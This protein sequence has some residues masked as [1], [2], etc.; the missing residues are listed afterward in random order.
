MLDNGTKYC[1]WTHRVFNNYCLSCPQRNSNRYFCPSGVSH[2][3]NFAAF[4]PS[5]AVVAANQAREFCFLFFFF[6][7]FKWSNETAKCNRYGTRSDF[8]IQ[9]D[10]HINACVPTLVSDVYISYHFQ[11][12]DT[13]TPPSI[14][15]RRI[16]VVASFARFRDRRRCLNGSV[17]YNAIPRLAWTL[18]YSNHLVLF[19]G[20]H[21]HSAKPRYYRRRYGVQRKSRSN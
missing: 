12:S 21:R 6:G 18:D 20:V 3:C 7:F 14:V 19:D 11:T 5:E 10:V 15:R 13:S 1:N 16:V 2:P 8:F 4:A 17:K 9:Y